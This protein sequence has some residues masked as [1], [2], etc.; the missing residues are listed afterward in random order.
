[1]GTLRAVEIKNGTAIRAGGLRGLF[2]FLK[3]YR[4]TR[5]ICVCA[6]ERPYEVEGIECLPW[7]DFFGEL[8][9]R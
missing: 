6:A 8:F 1:M 5:G 4:G 3:D 7:R 2:H 9:K